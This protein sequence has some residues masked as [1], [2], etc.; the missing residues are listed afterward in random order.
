MHIRDKRNEMNVDRSIGLLKAMPVAALA[1]CLTALPALAQRGEL[2][3]RTGNE[4]GVTASSYKYTE[5]GNIS[6][7][8]AK[9]GFDYSGTYAIGS[10][11][12]NRNDGWFVR[13]DLRFATGKGDYSGISGTLNNRPDWYYEIRGLIGKDFRF[14]DYTLSPYAGLGYR[15]LFNDLRGVTSTGAG[16]YRRE[17]NY[18]TIPVGVTHKM[19]LAN[20]AQLLTTAEYS[21][22]AR[23][24]QESKLSDANPANQDV[25]HTQRSGYGLRLGTMV[26]FATWSV[27]PSLILWHVK[28]SDRANNAP[29]TVEPRNNTYEIGVKALYHF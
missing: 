29:L 15:Y 11:W 23:G 26:R 21:F 12:P 16:G 5:P 24:R 1:C 13:G 4:I 17:S 7:K 22:L 2:A 8:A 18:T 19:N 28:E 3:T 20:Q 27:G 9:V 25:S 10:E 14:G 6:I